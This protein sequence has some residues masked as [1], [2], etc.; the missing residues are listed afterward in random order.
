MVPEKKIIFKVID[1]VKIHHD[2]RFENNKSI[3]DS[4]K[5]LLLGDDSYTLKK[6]VL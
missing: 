6:K 1:Y 3:I 2:I 5:I 4:N